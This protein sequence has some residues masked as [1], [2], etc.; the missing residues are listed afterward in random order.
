MIAPA[1]RS[2][3]R[4]RVAPAAPILAPTVFIAIPAAAQL[5]TFPTSAINPLLLSLS[6]LNGAHLTL[7]FP[8]GPDDTFKRFSATQNSGRYSV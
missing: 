4:F 7:I 2:R 5:P 3:A 1:G 6:N 8:S